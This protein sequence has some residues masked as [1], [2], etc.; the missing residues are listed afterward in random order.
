MENNPDDLEQ[1]RREGYESGWMQR[2][3]YRPNAL[4]VFPLEAI[5]FDYAK[6]REERERAKAKQS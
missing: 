6:W 4:F 1:A 2:H 3:I 5:K